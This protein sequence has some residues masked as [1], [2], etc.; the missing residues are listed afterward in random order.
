MKLRLLAA[1][2][3]I[4]MIVFIGLGLG[5]VEASPTIIDFE[6]EIEMKSGEEYEIEYEM[7]KN[8]IEA[9]YAVPSS[10]TVYGQEALPRIEAFLKQIKLVPEAD[11][12][13]IM[14]QIFAAFQIDKKDIEEM[15][16]DVKFDGGKRLKFEQAFS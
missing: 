10:V 11:K 1:V 4:S 7:K 6:L 12:D 8:Q 13:E 15:E 3:A 5:R 9:K 14:N 2:C 16:V